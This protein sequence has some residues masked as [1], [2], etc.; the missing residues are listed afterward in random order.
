MKLWLA[1]KDAVY[2]GATQDVTEHGLGASV[3]HTMTKSVL[4]KSH[5]VFFNN[6]FS[7][8][9]LAEYLQKGSTYYAATARADQID[10]LVALKQKTLNQQQSFSK[11]FSRGQVLCMEG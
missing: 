6:F 2:C 3:V 8:V 5:Y 7:T 9:P 1:S 4:G 11:C 10:W